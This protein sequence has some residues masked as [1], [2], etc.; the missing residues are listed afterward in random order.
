MPSPVG[1][2]LGGLIVALVLAP[3]PPP[4]EGPEGHKGHEGHE[5]LN[6]VWLR[7]LRGLRVPH[8]WWPVVGWCAVAACLPD[9]DFAW[10]RHNMETHSV[11]FAVMVGVATL[12]WRRSATVA[13]ACTL[14]VSTHVFFD[15]L[16]SDDREPLGVMA[17]WPLTSEFFYADAWVFAAISRHY[18]RSDFVLQNVLAVL[19]E[20][21]ILSPIVAA[22]W[23]YRREK[24]VARNTPRSRVRA[25]DGDP[26]KPGE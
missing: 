7:V 8:A 23:F 17:L 1:H 13:L 14:A 20:L 18:W 26:G 3:P 22:L 11:G 25:S 5:G 4:H 16:G 6:N 24:S 9:V 12:V 10:G 21:A 2:A 15:W 19:R